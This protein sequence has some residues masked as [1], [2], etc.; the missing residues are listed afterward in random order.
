MTSTELKNIFNSFNGKKVLLI[1]DA[2]IDAY[3]WGSINRMSPEAPVPV[4]DIE[5]YEIRLGGAANCALNIK[6]LGA[7]PILCSVLGK[8]IN[9]DQFQ[10]LMKDANLSEKGIILSDERKTT[11]KTRV[12]SEGKH[13]LRIDEEDTH[14]LEIEEEFLKNIHQLLEN[15]DVVILQDYNKGVLTK[16]IIAEIISEAKRRGI[17]KIVDP[18]KDNF[19]EY[20]DCD[21]FKPNLKEI[22]EGMEIEFNEKIDSELEGATYK[23][24]QELNAKGILLTLSSD[25]ICINSDE[26]FVHTPAYGGSVVD[27]SGAGDTVISV[28]SLLLSEGVSFENISKISCLSGGIVCQKVG[29]VPI[30]KDELLSESINIL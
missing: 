9:G 13:Q 21:I 24:K 20:K 2:M 1:G 8:D 5:K 10:Q 7:E 14:P 4:V 16:K 11:V 3:M 26:G 12:I 30:D 28:A 17:P 22:K 19:L 29:V 25:G 15:T 18:K 6:A 27:V 23:L